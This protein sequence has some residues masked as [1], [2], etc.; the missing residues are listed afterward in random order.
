MNPAFFMA[1]MYFAGVQMS[2]VRLYQTDMGILHTN[3]WPKKAIMRWDQKC[4]N[5]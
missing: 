5:F 3:Q 1:Y 2:L 4:L